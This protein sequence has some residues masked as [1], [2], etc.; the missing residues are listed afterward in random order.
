MKR[1]DLFNGRVKNPKRFL[2]VLIFVDGVFLAF[3]LEFLFI[4]LFYDNVD[5]ID[6]VILF[7]LCAVVL[8]LGIAHFVASITLVRIWPKHSRFTK[9]LW[10]EYLFYS[11][12][13]LELMN[14]VVDV[15]ESIN[16]TEAPTRILTIKRRKAAAGCALKVKLYVSSKSE[17]DLVLNVNDGTFHS[18]K[19]RYLGKVANGKTVQFEI[20]Q[21]RVIIVA[22]FDMTSAEWCRDT[23][24]IPAG[25]DEISLSG[26]CI[27]KPLSGNPFLFDK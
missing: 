11:Q 21:N 4:G 13:E 27:L 20:P 8:A 14:T 10:R 12:H 6:R 15:S 1:K 9:M 22:L 5:E 17:C 24:T 26:K 7:V 16:E 19:F 3:A 25:K 18:K 23:I 2:G